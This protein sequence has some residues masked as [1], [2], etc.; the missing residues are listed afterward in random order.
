M[1]EIRI[2][3]TDSNIVFNLDGPGDGAWFLPADV[4]AKLAEP[5]FITGECRKVRERF[6]E[7]ETVG[8]IAKLRVLQGR[9]LDIG[10]IAGRLGFPAPLLTEFLADA[11]GFLPAFE[12]DHAAELANAMRRQANNPELEERVKDKPPK[13]IPNVRPIR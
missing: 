2:S 13:R 3:F 6:R 9:G 11:R 7:L 4:A 5:G 12:R 10:A 1:K 8:A